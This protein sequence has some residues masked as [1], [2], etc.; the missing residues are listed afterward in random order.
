MTNLSRKEQKVFAESATNNGQ[1]GSLQVGTKITTND[2]DTLQAL[3]AFSTGWNDAAISGE[4][5]PALEE[6]QALHYLT[7][8]QIAYLMQKGIPEW[9]TNT[10]YYIGDIAREVGG[11]KLYQ[12]ITDS[13]SGNSLTNETYWELYSA[14]V[15]DLTIEEKLN[16][17]PNHSEELVSGSITYVGV[18]TTVRSE[19]AATTDDLDN[20][21]GG[22]TGDTVLLKTVGATEVITIRDNGV[23]G[24]NIA[25]PN[26]DPLVLNGTGDFIILIF[27]GSF[28]YPISIQIGD[29]N[30]SLKGL[31]LQ[32]QSETIS[33]GA[34]TYSGAYMVIDTEGAA[35]SDD[36]DTINGGT[37]GDVVKIRTTVNGRDVNIKSSTGNIL[38]P[39][40][41][42]A[43]LS[44]SDNVIE[45]I[46]I[47]SFWVQVSR[48]TTDDFAFSKT[49][50]GYTY[51]S[52]GM[53]L[54][55]GEY[56]RSVSTG[57]SVDITFPTTFP[58]NCFNVTNVVRNT[59]D[60]NLSDNYSY[61]VSKTTS[62]AR[63]GWDR[64][65]SYW[66]AIGN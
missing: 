5:L 32:P 31:N 21:T 41:V 9:E 57:G 11:N 66:F 59:D 49:T 56:D 22:V 35:S 62:G 42:D 48:S 17:A 65:G 64:A 8:R 26:D 53:I 46:L 58:N 39:N 43:R 18:N 24:G 20:I 63:V 13:N 61:V 55:W 47:G 1:F 34:I 3:G 25:L 27:R 51:L 16:L 40:D 29:R 28:W 45:L 33:S 6:F 38:L 23:S 14:E 52:N 2:T 15:K 44:R 7:T 60:V 54:Q 36:L 37:T 50:N 30:I 4:E 10:E 19:G 12:S